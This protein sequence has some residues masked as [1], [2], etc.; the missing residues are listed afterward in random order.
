MQHTHE[1]SNAR[2]DGN[3]TVFD[4][5]HCPTHQYLLGNWGATQRGENPG[6]VV[7]LEFK[8]SDLWGLWSAVQ[9]G[10]QS[11]YFQNNAEWAE[12]MVLR[13]NAMRDALPEVLGDAADPKRY[14]GR[15]EVTG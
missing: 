4:C 1:W 6:E 7:R 13:L 5:R 3:R 11:G 14:K 10:L 15:Q 8:D 9:Y 2:Y 12:Y